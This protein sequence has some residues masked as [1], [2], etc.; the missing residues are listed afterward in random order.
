MERSIPEVK[1]MEA[2]QAFCGRLLPGKGDP[3]GKIRFAAD[4][5]KGRL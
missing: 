2:G 3:A 1:V 4:C 5:P